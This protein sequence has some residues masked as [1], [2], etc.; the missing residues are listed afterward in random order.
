M[1][2]DALHVKGVAVPPPAVTRQSP[3][4]IEGASLLV[5]GIRQWA[6][7]PGM[8]NAALSVELAVHRKG[9]PMVG[10]HFQ[11]GERGLARVSTASVRAGALGTIRHIIVPTA[12]RDAYDVCFDGWPHLYLMWGDELDRVDTAPS[13]AA[14]MRR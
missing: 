9:S 10:T 13:E 11:E 8:I 1:V 4:V 12:A 5:V 14:H 6:A 2:N 3:L 7:S